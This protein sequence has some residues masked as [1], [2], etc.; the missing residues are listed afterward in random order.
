MCQRG[1]FNLKQIPM[2]SLS[3]CLSVFMHVSVCV[4]CV[5]LFFYNIVEVVNEF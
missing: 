5:L 1:I 3:V 4:F 2:R